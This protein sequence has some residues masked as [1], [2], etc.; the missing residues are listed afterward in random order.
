MTIHRAIIIDDEEKGRKTLFNLISE[1][2]NNI[3]IVGMGESVKTGIDAINQH[4]PDLVFLDISM[5]DGTGFDLLQKIPERNF[6]LIFV[7][8]HDEYAI[9]AFEFS[10]LHYILKPANVDDILEAVERATKKDGQKEKM[11]D[12]LNILENVINNNLKRIS[13]N[14]NDGLM[15]FELDGIVGFEADGNY[16]I[17]HTVDGSKYVIPKTLGKFEALLKECLFCR[18]HSKHLI[19]LTFVKRFIKSKN[20]GTLELYTGEMVPLSVRK[21]DEFLHL[22]STISPRA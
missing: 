16:S 2:C 1:Y 18:V 15:F 17:L 13:I 20:G 5:P 12:R 9:R 4:K 6:N 21:K 8:A 22:M 11:P 14:T 10:A 7:T 19:N 3:D